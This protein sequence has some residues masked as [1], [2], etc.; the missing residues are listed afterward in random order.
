MVFDAISERDD[1]ANDPSSTSLGVDALSGSIV[2]LVYHPGVDDR[3]K[4]FLSSPAC[5]LYPRIQGSRCNL[6]CQTNGCPR[7]DE[8][9]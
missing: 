9:R 4:S 7:L 3:R 6:M 5:D 8:T 1:T 2:I